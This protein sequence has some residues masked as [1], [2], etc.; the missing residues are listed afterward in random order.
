MR[1]FLLIGTAVFGLSFALTGSAQ[2][3][4]PCDVNYTLD[5]AGTISTGWIHLGNVTWPA[6]KQ[7][8]KELAI[9]HCQVTRATLVQY[10]PVGSA[11]FNA[12]C[13]AGGINV[14][15]DTKVGPLKKTKDGNCKAP[16]TC[17][18]PPCPWTGYSTP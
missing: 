14:Y 3:S 15:F 17:T 1:H 16:V 6:R 12:I 9:K 8:C 7:E 18:K 13:N 5:N 4:K 11:N 10:A 2:A